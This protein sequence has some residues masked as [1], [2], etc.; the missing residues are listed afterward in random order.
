MGNRFFIM[1]LLS[2]LALGAYLGMR[3]EIVEAPDMSV[4]PAWEPTQVQT[5]FPPV[6]CEG[7]PRPVPKLPLPIDPMPTAEPI[8][9]AQ[10]GYRNLAA[11][12]HV[13]SSDQPIVG[14]LPFITDGVKN[15]GE[16]YV[17]EL[18]EGPQWVQIDLARDSRIDLIW[19]WHRSG[20]DL[21]V[22]NDVIIEISNDPEFK[23]G[24]RQVFNNDYDKSSGRGLG[25]DLPYMES[26]YGKPIQ[27]GGLHGRYVRCYSNG[28]SWNQMN[29]Y[30]EIEVFG[31]AAVN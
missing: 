28:C 18:A 5:S 31:T 9:H 24:V 7:T 22:F 15:V 4:S 19:I 26:R 27:V 23:Q 20:M 14:S 29:S 8:A 21:M 25:K 13:T 6:L 3:R 16:G 30:T 12:K 11:G 10:R 1:M 2:V 17:V